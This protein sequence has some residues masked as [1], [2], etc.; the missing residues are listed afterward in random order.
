[1]KRAKSHKISS[2]KVYTNSVKTLTHIAK[3]YKPYSLKRDTKPVKLLTRL[4]LL[5]GT[6]ANQLNMFWI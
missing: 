6:V 5:L 4:K 1:M 3:G 2:V